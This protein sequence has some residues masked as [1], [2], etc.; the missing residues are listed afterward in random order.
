MKNCRFH[1]H[2]PARRAR[3]F[4]KMLQPPSQ[5]FQGGYTPQEIK[6]AYGFP[7]DAGAGAGQTIAVVAAS[8]QPNI[9][10]DLGVFSRYF[11]LPEAEITVEQIGQHPPHRTRTG[12][13]RSL[14]T[15]N[16]HMPWPR[17]PG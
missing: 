13:W 12:R 5:G 6:K 1:C 2:S 8:G 15:W 3:P 11:G 9:S 7:A 10:S 14:W 17:G 16:G 4:F